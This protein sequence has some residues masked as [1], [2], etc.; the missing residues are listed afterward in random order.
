MLTDVFRQEYHF[1]LIGLPFFNFTMD[2]AE[3]F[4]F[5]FEKEIDETFSYSLDFGYNSY[6]VLNG[7][8]V[9][10]SLGRLLVHC[11]PFLSKKP[12]PLI[13]ETQ[14]MITE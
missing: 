12:C 10:G 7:F 3:D 13:P 11:K 4:I 9:Y 8:P 6:R 5:S 14:G 2:F 1:H